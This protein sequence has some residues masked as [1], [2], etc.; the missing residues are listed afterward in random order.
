[1][2]D[3]MAQ[4][5]AETDLGHY[6]AA[7]RAL[8]SVVEAE[9][10]TP[11]LRA[12]GL[13]RLGAARRGASDFEGALQAFERASKAPGANRET[14]ALLVQALGGALPDAERWNAVWSRVSFVDDR[15]EPGRPTLAVVWPGVP[16]TTRG[17]KGAPITVHLVDADL[18][19]F[20][21]LVADTSGLNVVVNPRIH[22]LFTF[23]ADDAPWDQ[24]LDRILAANGL[25][26]QWQDNVLRI[27][28]PQALLPERQF[29]GRRVDVSW[30][31]G[32]GATR[33]PAKDLRE[34]LAE[35]AATGGASVVFD[36]SVQGAMVLKLN[37]VRWDQA[38][39]I[40]VAIN[41]LD[42]TRDGATLKVFPRPTNA[43]PR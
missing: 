8:T 30:G 9:D 18:Q 39:H 41:G 4:G 12:E 15:S 29:S 7:I 26:Y 24:C 3:L 25:A 13:V 10:A 38:F 2:L 27:A 16:P 35:L 42:W 21:R 31:T 34:A 17:Y 28:Q 23:D 43:E 20:F 37:Q 5:K 19:D 36:P 14:K 40:V 6:D 32:E 1:V 33:S 11:A 22:G